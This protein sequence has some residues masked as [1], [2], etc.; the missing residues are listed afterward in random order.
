MARDGVASSGSS[1]VDSSEDEG[2]DDDIDGNGADSGPGAGSSASASDPV[3]DAIVAAALRDDDDDGAGAG[4]DGDGDYG[5]S[6]AV[7]TAAVRTARRFPVATAIAGVT[8]VA[9]AARKRWAFAGMEGASGSGAAAAAGGRPGLGCCADPA[10]PG[11]GAAGG[12]LIGSGG[13]AARFVEETHG[14]SGVSYASMQHSRG[15][16]A[17]R[18]AAQRQAGEAAA[19][20]RAARIAGAST[21]GGAPGS[22]KKE[23]VGFGPGSSGAGGSAGAAAP[24]FGAAAGLLTGG[25]A[26]PLAS[27]VVTRGAPPE[28]ATAGFARAAA[29]AAGGGGG[30]GSDLASGSGGAFGPS[31]RGVMSG[32]GSVSLVT[33]SSFDGLTDA[34]TEDAN[35]LARASGANGSGL[36]MRVAGSGSGGAAGSTLGDAFG[37]FDPG[38]WGGG[39]PGSGS[40]IAGAAASSALALLDTERVPVAHI[41]H[42][43]D[44][45]LLYQPPPSTAPRHLHHS[46]SR[47]GGGG[48][49]A[50][51]SRGSASADAPPSAAYMATGGLG[52]LRPPTLYFT[53]LSKDRWERQSVHGYGALALPLGPGIASHRVRT[54]VPSAPL[55][56][57]EYAYYL[58]GVGGLTDITYVTVPESEAPAIAAPRR[59][60]A[61]GSDGAGISVPSAAAAVQRAEVTLSKLGMAAATAGDIAVRT[62]TVLVRPPPQASALTAARAA[63]AQEAQ[64]AKAK[65]V[66]DIIAQARTLR[67]RLAA[68]DGESGAST[69][70]STFG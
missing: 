56:D 12:S 62:H 52:A 21:F 18:L 28:I 45:H 70:V 36:G 65:S 16:V 64:A 63:A 3:T 66:T 22:P 19:A 39:G 58:G 14:G 47:G 41:C 8:Q 29:A 57:Q 10:A 17:A 33:T 5:A 48:G 61:G 44:I 59:G 42:P 50:S 38:G 54:W 2:Y 30:D 9:R 26:G 68:G 51:A 6:S 37:W 46:D 49:S 23:V 15:A 32:A 40:G 43:L 24:A 55:R 69:P 35:T 67:A 11:S 34:L 27:T 4:G 60:G 7:S 13:A 25:S 1:I 53:V 31:S 20:A